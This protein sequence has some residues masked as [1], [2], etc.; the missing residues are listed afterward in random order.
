M[1]SPKYVSWNITIDTLLEMVLKDKTMIISPPF[2]R[3]VVWSP[4]QKAAFIN[5]IFHGLNCNNFIFNLEEINSKNHYTCI[6]GKQRITTLIEYRNN[7]FPV[8]YEGVW[9]YYDKLGSKVKKDIQVLTPENK[10]KFKFY[11]VICYI[12]NNLSY[13]DQVDVFNRIQ[14]G[15]ALTRGELVSSL[16]VNDAVTNAF[17][18]YCDSKTISDLFKKF[19][20]QEKIL[21][22]EHHEFIMRLMLMVSK[23]ILKRPTTKQKELYIKNIKT[24]I[25]MEKEI[26]KID[27]T[28]QIVFSDDVLGNYTISSKM[29]LGF[30]TIICIWFSTMEEDEFEGDN[31]K[32]IL[33]TIRKIYR[34]VQ[35]EFLNEKDIALG[36]NTIENTE[37]TIG[38]LTTYY[39]NMLNKNIVDS[40]DDEGLLEEEP[41]EESIEEP[42]IV[43]KTINKANS[44]VNNK[45]VTA[46]IATKPVVTKPTATKPVAT[47]PVA[48]VPAK[49][50]AKA[51]AKPVTRVVSK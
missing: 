19:L 2:Q 42:I 30:I 8:K 16:F 22:K 23:N 34:E 47:K 29:P 4:D 27:N 5:S 44:I 10:T 40:E 37:K 3:G 48:K 21:R 36:K 12:Y 17:K 15:S 43:K 35:N 51:P 45:L 31:K 6:D 13:E 18:S 14:K 25:A 20:T 33:S 11:Q 41:I 50:V 9:Y 7:D 26:G 28:I 49:P 46:K 24:K 32:Y 1:L 38:R 39:T